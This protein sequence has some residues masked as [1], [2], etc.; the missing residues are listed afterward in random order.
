MASVTFVIVP[1]S[2]PAGCNIAW[3]QLIEPTVPSNVTIAGGATVNYQPSG[4][5]ISLLNEPVVQ[6]ACAGATFALKFSSNSEIAE[7][8]NETL[9]RS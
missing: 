5:S 3:F 6:N 8:G 7:R 2:L 4:A 9:P 1:A